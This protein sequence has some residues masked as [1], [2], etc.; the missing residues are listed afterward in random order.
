[1]LKTVNNVTQK[2]LSNNTVMGKCP[3]QAGNTLI[4]YEKSNL[5]LSSSCQIFFVE[6][7]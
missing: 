7:S 6:W 5:L 4:L 2:Y 3:L 1:M